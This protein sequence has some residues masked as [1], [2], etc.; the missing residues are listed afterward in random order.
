[1]R[2]L[3]ILVFAAPMFSMAE[4]VCWE[5]EP[6]KEANQ[7]LLLN[8]GQSTEKKLK[9]IC[10]DFDDPNI[11]VVVKQ[12]G[13][14]GGSSHCGG[15]LL[16][17]GKTIYEFKEKV[18]HLAEG[19]SA[20]RLGSLKFYLKH[21]IFTDMEDAQTFLKDNDSI[22]AVLYSNTLSAGMFSID[23]QYAFGDDQQSALKQFKEIVNQLDAQ[24][25]LSRS[26]TIEQFTLENNATI[27]KIEGQTKRN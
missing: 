17:L 5:V 3:F 21:N 12:N 15:N 4:E 8:D 11:E 13:G 26:A 10:F 6:V 24:K 23:K 1:M 2:L 20:V 7:L 18:E 19:E 27:L 25:E 9:V 22:G 16:V 14:C